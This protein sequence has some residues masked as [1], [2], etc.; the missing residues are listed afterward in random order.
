MFKMI[1]DETKQLVK[2]KFKEGIP[3]YK[4]GKMVNISTNSVYKILKEENYKNKCKRCGCEIEARWKKKGRHFSYCETC[5]KII[6]SELVM[7]T[8]KRRRKIN[9][10]SIQKVSIGDKDT[11]G[12]IYSLNHSSLGTSNLAE[13]YDSVEDEWNAIIKEHDSIFGKKKL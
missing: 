5:R 10:E 11:H 8:Y 1:Q 3:V 12:D 2:Q 9:E 6:N 13:H 4:I 7:R